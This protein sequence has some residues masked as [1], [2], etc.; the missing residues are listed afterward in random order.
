[1]HLGDTIGEG[2][3]LQR[4]TV[5]DATK[6]VDLRYNVRTYCVRSVLYTY[7][8]YYAAFNVPRVSNED[9]ESQARF[10]LQ[11]FKLN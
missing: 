2:A 9:D 4:W 6:A 5:Q 3:K 1:M 7:Y 10:C 8:Y 11:Y